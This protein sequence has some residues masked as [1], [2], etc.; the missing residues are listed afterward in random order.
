MGMANDGT[1]LALGAVAV[2]SGAAMMSG[3]GSRAIDLD[4]LIARTAP[5]KASKPLKVPKTGHGKTGVT[6]HRRRTAD[7]M[8]ADQM[9]RR[10]TPRER[11]LAPRAQLRDLERMERDRQVRAQR[12]ARRQIPD[13]TRSAPV[14]RP[15]PRRSAGRDVGAGG[16]WHRRL[17]FVEG[18]SAK[19]WSLD[20]SGMGAVTVGWGRID[21]ARS[22]QQITFSDAM[23]R[24]REKLGKGYVVVASRGALPS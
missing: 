19:F 6:P 10:M 12:P 13:P 3:R 17:E 22:E 20:G 14:P 18:T 24:L 23:K 16:A 8:A 9:L 21:G 5:K 15:S 11:D 4:A 2:V 1:W 7:E